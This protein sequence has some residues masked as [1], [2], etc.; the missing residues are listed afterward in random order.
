MAALGIFLSM[1]TGCFAK[2]FIENQTLDG[3]GMEDPYAPLMELL[4]DN[5]AT[6]DGRWT[7]SINGYTLQLFL[8]GE[9]VYDNT[10]EFFVYGEDV[11]ERT[12]LK[13]YD[14]EF[15]SD[16][17]SVSGVIE[18]F[19]TENGLLYM[20]LVFK[21]GTGENIV[22]E[23]SDEEIQVLDGDGTCVDNAPLLL[24]LQGSWV[25][26][27][28][29]WKLTIEDY[30]L[31]ILNEEQKVY[32]EDYNFVFYSGSDINEHTELELAA[33]ELYRDGM[34]CFALIEYL[35]SEN[36]ALYME[37]SYED[38]DSESVAFEKSAE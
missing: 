30:T 20:E 2:K 33:Y 19:Y 14:S 9:R 26:G 35:Y 23:K 34:E 22:F 10:F 36:G 29:V 13:L 1:L 6:S 8:T 15:K 24:A 5:W 3:P 37:V 32:C 4:S 38:R 28:G 11:N 31:T 21:D 25:S 18:Q 27:D 17:G 16:D 7:A 12:E